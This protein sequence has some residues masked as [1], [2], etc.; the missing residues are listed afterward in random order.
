VRVSPVSLRFLRTRKGVVN[1][2]S[3]IWSIRGASIK[4]E[5]LQA[6][7]FKTLHE[8]PREALHKIVAHGRIAIAFPAQAF[9]VETDRPYFFDSA[10]V[11]VPPIWREQPGP[12]ND[13]SSFH[14]MQHKRPASGG[15][16]LD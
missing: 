5:K 16:D 1:I 11:E 14:R 15:M 7:G 13:F 3:V 4:I 12:P 6:R 8:N 2:G 9:T 10:H